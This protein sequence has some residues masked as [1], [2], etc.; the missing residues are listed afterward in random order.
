MEGPVVLR[1]CTRPCK[2]VCFVDQ[3]PHGCRFCSIADWRE[4][5]FLFVLVLQVTSPRLWSMFLKWWWIV[6]WH[7]IDSVI[8]ICICIIYIYMD[9][10]IWAVTRT[11]VNLS[12][13][14]YIICMYMWRFFSNRGTPKSSILVGFSIINHPAIGVPPL[15]ETP[16]WCICMHIYTYIYIYMYKFDIVTWF[17]L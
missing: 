9:V 13:Y 5:R 2:T 1:K 3:Y 7:Y 15:Q 8:Y 6:I 16:I 14:T 17:D 10:S 11:F 4:L 12:W